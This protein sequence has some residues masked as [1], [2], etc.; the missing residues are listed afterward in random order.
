MQTTCKLEGG[1]GQKFGKF[2]NV[3]Y[4]RPLG[5]FVVRYNSL[6]NDEWELYGHTF[7]IDHLKWTLS[8]M[9]QFRNGYQMSIFFA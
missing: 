4:E 9:N 5:A 1:G 8:S 3:I 2:A 6:F 7:P